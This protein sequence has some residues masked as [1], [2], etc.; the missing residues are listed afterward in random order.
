MF[1]FFLKIIAPDNQIHLL[2]QA[3]MPSGSGLIQWLRFFLF[4]Y[5]RPLRAYFVYRLFRYTYFS[6]LPVAVGFCVD[7][8]QSG[9]FAQNLNFYGPIG[10]IYLFIYAMLL[11]NTW[12]FKKELVLTEN[13]SRSL[14]L[15]GMSV[16][17]SLPV[18]WH[19]QY[20]TGRKLELVM[21]ARRGL[22]ELLRVIRWQAMPIVGSL[23]G[24][25]ISLFIF[26]GPAYFVILLP[27]FSTLYLFCSW[28]F[29]RPVA[30]LY[31]TYKDINS[32]LIAKLYEFSSSIVTVKSLSLEKFI[33]NKAYKLESDSQVSKSKIYTVIFRR[34]FFVN[35]V[36]ALFLVLIS[37]LAVRAALMQ[38]ITPG[39]CAGIIML[40]YSL[41]V[42]L[43]GISV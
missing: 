18:E 12:V 37:V 39:S 11:A 28:Y 40:F 27:L 21:D 33:E 36:A 19:S 30:K 38:Q 24:V 25:T 14:A 41:W 15:L 16:L 32:K 31:E 34:W 1:K 7:R 4:P 5:R 10:G 17:H 2:D 3:C 43:E 35:G 13:A 23:V 20:P 8:L 42:S 22:L 9:D 26:K 6:L 29:N